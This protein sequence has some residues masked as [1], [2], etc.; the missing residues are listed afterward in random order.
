[1]RRGRLFFDFLVLDLLIEVAEREVLSYLFEVDRRSKIDFSS[2]KEAPKMF[3]YSE[4]DQQL[5]SNSIKSAEGWDE[6]RVRWSRITRY[7]EYP[8]IPDEILSLH[9]CS[10]CVWLLYIG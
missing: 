2:G 1:M 9:T 7:S 3:C 4:F 6:K 10:K 5:E 8:V